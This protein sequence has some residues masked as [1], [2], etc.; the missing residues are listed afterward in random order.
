[1]QLSPRRGGGGLKRRVS[2]WSVVATPLLSYAWDSVI[3]GDGGRGPHFQGGRA[4][5]NLCFER[6]L[7]E[8]FGTLGPGCPANAWRDK[9]CY[10]LSV[11]PT[12]VALWRVP[13]QSNG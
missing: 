8:G 9:S 12:D 5:R 3:P 13:P 1:M 10:V 4:V 2:L 6:R 7:V 11:R